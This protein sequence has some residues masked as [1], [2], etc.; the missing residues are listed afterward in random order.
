MNKEKGK[1]NSLVLSRLLLPLLLLKVGG[2]I[3]GPG[4]GPQQVCLGRQVSFTSC[5]PQS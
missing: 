4:L 5:Q 1:N 2:H 3:W